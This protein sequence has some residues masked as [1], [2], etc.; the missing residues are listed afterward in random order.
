MRSIHLCF[1]TPCSHE[2]RFSFLYLQPSLS[3]VSSISA[4]G[5]MTNCSRLQPARHPPTRC[6]LR[7]IAAAAA[8]LSSAARQ[9]GRICREV[10][11]T[12]AARQLSHADTIAGIRSGHSR[13]APSCA[14]ACR[15]Q[16]SPFLCQTPNYRN[17]SLSNCL[18]LERLS[19]SL[20][21][22]VARVSIA[23]LS[24]ARFAVEWRMADGEW[25]GCCWCEF[26]TRW[27]ESSR[28]ASDSEA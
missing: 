16:S 13:E 23:L 1:F 4:L 7:V 18:E 24:D 5:S 14:R 2:R 17:T 28:V 3:L 21:A 26:P 19:A 11:F 15:E 25:L 27:C 8:A 20:L 12:A 9:A 6:S 22:P 10:I